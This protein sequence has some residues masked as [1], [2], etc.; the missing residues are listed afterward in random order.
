MTSFNWSVLTASLAGGLGVDFIAI[1]GL[2][3]AP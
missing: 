1:T 3:D 2:I